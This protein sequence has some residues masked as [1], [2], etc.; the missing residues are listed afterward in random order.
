MSLLRKIYKTLA[1]ARWDNPPRLMIEQF[2]ANAA[3]KI[4]RG[5]LVL[6]AGAGECMY[7]S[8]FSH[9]R[10]ISYDKAIGDSSWD[11]TRLSVIGDMTAL[12]F[13]EGSFDAILSTQT[14]E[15]VSEP[16]LVIAQMAALLKPGGC[17]Y[18]SVPFLGD[19]LHQEPYDFYRYTKY[20]LEHLLEHARLSS[21]SILPMGGLGI[22]FCCYFWFFVI[23]HLSEPFA[24][25]PRGWLAQMMRKSARIPMLFLARLC[26]AFVMVCSNKDIASNKFT[27]G[28]T[29]I[30][31]K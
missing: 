24:P 31:Q 16:Q 25:L 1:L 3:H 12:P 13:R 17:L 23:Y 21:V 10:Y 20:S 2:V 26:T 19:P 4:G 27:Y 22:L 9:C 15:H 7:A 28:Y 8:A 14:L 6:D 29:V 30:A 18:L 5:S 11:Y